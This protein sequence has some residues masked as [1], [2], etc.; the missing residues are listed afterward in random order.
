MDNSFVVNRGRQVDG[1]RLN[2]NLIGPSLK[3][4]LES[5]ESESEENDRDN[6]L[7]REK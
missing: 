1:P 4:K 5:K 2:P 7:V 3:Q 6:L